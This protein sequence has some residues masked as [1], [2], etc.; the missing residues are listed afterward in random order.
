MADLRNY[1]EDIREQSLQGFSPQG[2]GCID[3]K[4][5][6]AAAQRIGGILAQQWLEA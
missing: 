4:Q 3:T 6:Q 1:K 5:P 2:T